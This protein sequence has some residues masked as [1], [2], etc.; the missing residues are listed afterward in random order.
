MINLLH[1]QV[2]LFFAC[3]NAGPSTGAARQIYKYTVSQPCI[4][5]NDGAGVLPV[6]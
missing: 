4:L 2:V 1:G 3:S 5:L 6:F